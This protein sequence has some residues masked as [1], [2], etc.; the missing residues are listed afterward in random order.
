MGEGCGR[1]RRASAGTLG[2]TLGELRRRQV[3]T[4][5]DV[6]SPLDGRKLPASGGGDGGG[7]EFC[8]LHLVLGY[9]PPAVQAVL[10]SPGG[11]GVLD[12]IGRPAGAEP[13]Q[14]APVAH[15]ASPALAPGGGF[16]VPAAAA[17]AGGPAAAERGGEAAGEDSAGVG[18]A[19]RLGPRGEPVVEYVVEVIRPGARHGGRSARFAPRPVP[20]LSLR[21][22][23][24]RPPL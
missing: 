4:W 2:A 8:S 11:V 21:P 6:L 24:P 19:M 23:R 1:A 12:A 9:E 14:P 22:P 20:D 7:G 3:N 15:A 10:G 17:R 18:V 13:Q 5:F 16:G